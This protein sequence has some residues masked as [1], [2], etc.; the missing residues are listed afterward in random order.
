MTMMMLMMMHLL[1][2]LLHLFFHRVNLLL[3]FGQSV[4]I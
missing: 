2:H 3:T 4:V 1:S